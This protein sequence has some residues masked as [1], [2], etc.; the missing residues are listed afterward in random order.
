M[1]KTRV[2]IAESSDITLL[3]LLAIL[4]SSRSIEVVDTAADMAEGIKL[5]AKH[6]PDLCLISDSF[7]NL[8]IHDF[9]QNLYKYDDNAKVVLLTD[10]LDINYLNQALKA[11]ITGCLLKSIDKKNLKQSLISAAEGE[12]VFSDAISNLMTDRYADLAQNKTGQKSLDKITKREG[13]ILQMII[14]GYTS[15]EIAK[16]LYISP[17]TVETH[18]SNL[19]Q[20]LKMKNTA[21][22]VRF[23]LEKGP[24]SKT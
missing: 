3:G 10:S 18:R 9:M 20:K 12:K 21:A 13:E 14:D 15:Q 11:G 4:N 1:A 8:N 16:E 19:L 6:A 22:L 24:F 7:R 17:R 5:F 23:A 2:L